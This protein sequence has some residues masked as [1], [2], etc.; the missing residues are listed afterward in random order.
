MLDELK[1]LA[2]HTLIY[3]FGNIVSKL[4]GFLLIPFYTHYLHP[5][6]Y[7]T[8]ELLDLSLSL[9]L[10]IVNACIAAPVLRFY[11]EY[12]DT[13]K[14]RRVIS[15]AFQV[16]GCAAA[17]LMLVGIH[18]ARQLSILILR[19]P[20]HPLCLQVILIT[21]FFACV[22]R[23]CWNY[24]IA[25]Q[26]SALVTAL[27]VSFLVIT[28]S[29]NVYFVAFAHLGVLGVLYSGLIAR[30]ITTVIICALTLRE[31]GFGFDP[32]ILKACAIFGAP[33]ILSNF[34]AFVLNFS[35]RFF[36][37]R[38]Q[39]LAV[40]GTYAL[41]YKFGFMLS[42]LL[43]QPFSMIWSARMYEIDQRPNGR[44]LFSRI[45]RLFCLILMAG[46][47]GISASAKEVIAIVAAPEFRVAYQ[48]VPLVALAY[49]FQG[50]FYYFQT[51]I[52]IEK[53]TQYMALTGAIG[54]G[55]N[56]LLN[57]LLI[58]RY[59][60]TGAAWA[61]IL[62][63]LL[64]AVLAYVFSQAVYTIPF[65]PGKLSWTIMLGITMYLLSTKVNAGSVWFCGTL[66]LLSVPLFLVAVY[67]SGF[68]EK[69]ETERLKSTLGVWWTRFREIGAVLPER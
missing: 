19:S 13:Y 23:V 11:Y 55:A 44:E 48:I 15:T 58:P 32:G 8:I 35:D 49:V 18:F 20:A 67:C 68:F 50:M 3:G 41:G 39:P 61:T 10:L 38:F 64:M 14:K 27:E 53:K 29:L 47:L 16:G 7:G 30:V 51:G 40:V 21:F 2:K 42:F 17:T 52:L 12:D 1:K 54:A 4:A 66:K 28:L 34:G 33:L 31:V 57:F 43:I 60:G 9:L 25:R 65:Q 69:D 46:A 24:L 6:E 59:S 56:V 45:G 36:L 26:R 62:S 37:G 5:A 63:F 22:N